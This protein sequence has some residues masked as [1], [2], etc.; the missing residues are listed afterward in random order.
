MSP[1]PRRPSSH[2]CVR[3]KPSVGRLPSSGDGAHILAAPLQTSTLAALDTGVAI[4]TATLVQ[5]DFG[6]AMPRGARAPIVVTAMAMD[7]TF[8]ASFAGRFMLA[9]LKLHTDRSTGAGARVDLEDSNGTPVATL[10]WAPQ[11]PGAAILS[12]IAA[13]ALC[14]GSAL[15]IFA[16]FFYVRGRRMAQGLVASE[17]RATHLAYYDPLTGLPNRSLFFDRLGVA[18]D[19]TRRGAPPVAVHCIDLDRF[20]EVND[21]YGHH[22][23]DELIKEA[24]RRMSAQCRASDTFSRLSGD[25]FAIVQTNATADSAAALATRLISVIEQPFDIADTRIFVGAS[26]GISI[27]LDIKTEA[28]EALRHADLAMYRAKETGKGSYCFFEIEMD[29]AVKTRKALEA[30]LRRAL[31]NGELE[32]VYQP[33]VDGRDVVVGVEALVRWRHPT[34]GY[35]SPAYFVPIAEECG[36]ISDLG[37]FTLRRVR[38]QPPLSGAQC[39]RQH[40]RVACANEGFRLAPLG[41]DGGNRHRPAPFR[42]G[43][44]RRR[45]VGR[46]PR[47]A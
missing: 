6:T 37:M 14:V 46:R 44:H 24:A 45:A 13:P 11:T 4:L 9:D 21:T 2:P 17:A 22:V 30:D 23:G 39:R 8:L 47:H 32:M 19:Q 10:T 3:P 28:V 18:L 16:V 27:V 38:G 5:P 25:E 1:K 43:D 15:A 20:K 41:V 40:L 35:I 7:S 26:V 42:T 29:A 33:Q 12:K 31:A 34:R 36:L